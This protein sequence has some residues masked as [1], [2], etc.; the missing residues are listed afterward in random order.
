MLRGIIQLLLY[1]II[2][3]FATLNIED[4]TNARQVAEYM[5][6]TYLLYLHVSGQFHLIV[7]LLHMFGFNLPETHHRYLLASSFTD[8]WRRINIYWKDFIMKL[9]FYPMFFAI[10]ELG[11][12]K[13]IA[14]ATIGAFFVTWALHTWQWFWFRGSFLLTSQD[15]TFW[16][17][18]ALLVTVNALYEAVVGRKRSLTKPVLT[19]WSQV[20]IGLKTIATFVTICSL[21][22]MWSSQSWEELQVLWEAAAD[23]SVTDVL[24]ILGGLA[25]LGIAGVLWGSSSP[26]TIQAT[27]VTKSY[28]GVSHFWRSV[29]TTSFGA[30]AILALIP[31]CHSIGTTS[32][33]DML[34]TLRQDQMNSRDVDWQRRGY[35][36]EL[37]V[38]RA[39][40]RTWVDAIETPADWTDTR[41]YQK[42][43][44]FLKQEMVPSTSGR[45]CGTLV[46]INQWGMR[47][48]EYPKHKSP[49]TYRILL[50][51]SSHEMG[52]GVKDDETF[53]NLVEDRLNQELAANGRQ[54]EILNLSA[55]G[56]GVLRKLVHLE[57]KGLDF[58]PD[59]V[60]FALNVGDDLFDMGDLS[61]A[62]GPD[63]EVPYGYFREV[64]ERARVDHRLERLVI[65]HRLKPFMPDV[66]RW[67]FARLRTVCERHDAWT[68][69]LYRPSVRDPA[70]TEAVRKVDILSRADE[71]GIELIDLSAAF[72]QIE[73]RDTLILAPWD[74]HTNARGHQ[75]LADMLYP[76]LSK[77]LSVDAAVREAEITA[78]GST[79]IMLKR[80]IRP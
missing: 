18:L 53:E 44:D 8:F 45:V 70:Q 19:F 40:Y 15:I 32:S 25:L 67:A 38:V 7:G 77:K 4:V 35:Y 36:E 27:T 24:V 11:T 73:D 20:G 6:A 34:A 50:V 26:E 55:G 16:S 12:L 52:A 43:N 1:R 58:S 31:V 46:S 42:R 69:A 54:Y 65:K 39:N 80:K 57:R 3:H 41:L 68:I 56:Y 72:D 14:L 49:N 75:L 21:W 28:Q 74:D 17:V 22:T 62:V 5:V 78:T 51:G 61:S 60:I 71:A 10:K 9:F 63:A 37:D 47:D 59:G 48:R 29:G 64:F 30:I 76:K 79:S 13:A 2:Y 23:C 66:Y 33:I